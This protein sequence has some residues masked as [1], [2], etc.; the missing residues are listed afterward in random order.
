MAEAAGGALPD[1]FTPGGNLKR[2]SVRG[3]T[4]ALATQVVKFSLQLG[5]TAVL[6]RLLTPDDYG[7]VAMVVAL[8]GFATLFRDL[9]LS[10]ATIQRDKITHEEVSGL[11]WIN[12]FF[13]LAIGFIVALCAPL[14]AWFYGRPDLRWLTLAFAALVPI[15]SLA[16]QHEALLQRSMRYVSLAIRDLIA[17]I[18]GIAAGIWSASLGLGY[19]ALV[20]MQATIKTAN[21]LTLW[22]QSGWRPGRPRWGPGLGRMVRFGGTLTL[23]N[24]LGYFLQGLDS[25]VLGYLFGSAGVGLYNRA[26]SL[27][28]KPLQQFMPTVMSVATSAFSRLASDAESFERNTLRLLGMVACAAGLVVALVVATADWMV[29]LMLGDQW[30]GA[31]P[32]VAALSLFAFVEPSASLLGTLLIARGLPVKVVQW[33]LISVPIILAGLAAGANWGPLGVAIALA[34]SGLLV[35]APLFFWYAANAL[36]IPPRLLFRAVVPHVVLGGAVAVC[37]LGFRLLWSPGPVAGIPVFAGLGA[38][39]Y[40]GL[41]WLRP[42]G[43]AMIVDGRALLSHLRVEPLAVRRA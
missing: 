25:V 36:S 11:F 30:T 20:I 26:Q 9:G 29:A 7:S 23:S 1:L 33:R 13:G 4:V 17:L 3:G 37:L 32:I 43:R 10:T 24:V 28:Q 16:T 27:L 5:S 14:A 12:V 39:V 15:D 22:W 31:V 38:V 40:L 35:R 8:L 21:V 6:A 42:E 18:V 2:R 34:G 41:L 19:W